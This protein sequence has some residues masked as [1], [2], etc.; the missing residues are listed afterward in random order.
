MKRIDSRRKIDASL[1]KFALAVLDFDAEPL[2]IDNTTIVQLRD[3]LVGQMARGDEAA[4]R[5]VA[6]LN[7]W[8]DGQ[9]YCPRC[10]GGRFIEHGGEEIR[11]TACNGKGVVALEDR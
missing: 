8:M 7:L 9:R 6:E 2:T 3:V 1:L 5:A 11:C 10:S 4:R